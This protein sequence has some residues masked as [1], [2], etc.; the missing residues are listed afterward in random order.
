MSEAPAKTKKKE[1]KGG[2]EPKE[3]KSKKLDFEKEKKT[4]EEKNTEEEALP[5][6]KKT[7]TK[8]NRKSVNNLEKT[9]KS[10]KKENR[11]SVSSIP[12][13]PSNLVK[14]GNDKEQHHE[15]QNQKHS[16]ANKDQKSLASILLN[17]GPDSLFSAEKYNELEK[18]LNDE[19]FRMDF[20]KEEGYEL[21]L[22]QMIKSNNE[23]LIQKGFQIIRNMYEQDIRVFEKLFTN[24]PY[25]ITCIVWA[26]VKYRKHAGMKKLIYELLSELPAIAKKDERSE[27]EMQKLIISCFSLYN[28]KAGEPRMFSHLLVYL[29]DLNDSQVEEQTIIMRLINQIIEMFSHLESRIAMRL[30]FTSFNIEEIMDKMYNGGSSR[31]KQEIDSFK[32]GSINDSVAYIKQHQD[33]ISEEMYEGSDV[34]GIM[35]VSCKRWDSSTLRPII[36]QTMC[37]LLHLPTDEL[38]GVCQWLFINKV[39]SQLSSP[40]K[41]TFVFENNVDFEKILSQIQTENEFKEKIEESENR[42]EKLKKKIECRRTKKLCFRK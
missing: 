36:F 39:V 24:S 9:P 28:H 8:Q 14:S 33:L 23:A 25:M 12:D 19:K 41:N 29:N 30:Q 5:S 26:L 17:L 1:K 4:K 32:Q 2:D 3:G 16:E 34:E 21:L 11:S 7:K 42:I 18:L 38:Y 27:A 37:D 35:R 6:P 22:K 40:Y 31:L 10:K 20:L 13:M 15:P